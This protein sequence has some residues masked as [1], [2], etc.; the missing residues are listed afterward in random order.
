MRHFFDDDEQKEIIA[1]A[2]RRLDRYFFSH[3]AISCSINGDQI[4]RVEEDAVLDNPS[5][6][7]RT[8]KKLQSESCALMRQITA[9]CPGANKLLTK[10]S[11][12]I[13]G[14]ETRLAEHRSFVI[15]LLFGLRLAG[16]SSELAERMAQTWSIQNLYDDSPAPLDQD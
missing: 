12:E 8:E 1:N 5:S 2:S 16:I 3:E 4:T 13:Q 7:T 14:Q 15:G 10:L 9:M 11:D 6:Y